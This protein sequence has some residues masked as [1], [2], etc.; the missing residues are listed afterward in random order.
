MYYSVVIASPVVCPLAPCP[1]DP[2][3]PGTGRQRY[4]QKFRPEFRLGRRYVL[5]FCLGM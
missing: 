5:F 1:E 4:L 2:R 3:E